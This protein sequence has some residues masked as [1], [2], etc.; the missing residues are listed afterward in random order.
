MAHQHRISPTKPVSIAVD[1]GVFG[2]IELRVDVVAVWSRLTADAITIAIAIHFALWM[3]IRTC[4]GI[5]RWLSIGCRRFILT[6]ARRQEH[7]QATYTEPSH[8]RYPTITS[9]SGTMI[10]IIKKSFKHWYHHQGKGI[11]ESA[12]KT[13]AW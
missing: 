10:N 13:S 5:S 6:P 11:G 1:V 12:L 7:N 4:V 8:G 9:S 3:P 2:R